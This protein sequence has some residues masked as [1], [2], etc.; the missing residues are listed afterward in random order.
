MNRSTLCLT[1]VLASALPLFTRSAD[2]HEFWLSP[3]R[4]HAAAD[5]TLSV[6]A[7][8]G[9]GFRGEQSPFA[10]TRTER[11]LLRGAGESDL[12]PAGVNGAFQWARWIAG[13]DG[14]AL[15]AFQSGF[16]SIELPAAPFEAYL[17]LVGLDGPL[18][19][20]ARLGKRAGPGRERFARCA[21][22]WISGSNAARATRP[23]GL[24]LELV[25]LDAPG[26]RADL[27]LRVLWHGTPLAG[28]LVR[29]WVQPL[30][31]RRTPR[32][33][34]QRDSVATTFQ[35]RTLLDGSVRIPTPS[36]GEWMISV[37]HM[38][39]STEPRTADWDSYWASLTFAR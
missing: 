26:S 30:G 32:E 39:T 18:A 33:I 13:D 15:V 25:P 34:V 14:G 23:V 17:R 16:T 24:A 6:N 12:R 11:L 9:T 20:R 38:V 19:V 36:S 22:V 29:A 10:T 8:V 7:R 3:S 27:K 31:A 5:D 28:A 21:K 1:L 2:A 4:Y 35:T 37:V